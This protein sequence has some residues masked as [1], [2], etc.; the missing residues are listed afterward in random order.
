MKISPSRKS[1]FEILSKF[2]KY[3]NFKIDE[4][5]DNV[6][7]RLNLNSKDRSL[8]MQIVYG[9]LRNKTLLQKILNKFTITN[10]KNSSLEIRVILL[11]SLFQLL[12]LDRVPVYAIVNDG[13]NLAKVMGNKKE[14]SF[15]NAV[16]RRISQIGNMEKIN[17]DIREIDNLSVRFSHPQWIIN[18]LKQRVNENEIKE[19]LQF[20]NSIPPLDIRITAKEISRDD[21]IEEIKK[22]IPK[23]DI[24][25]T[26]FSP[27][28]I[29]ITPPI[30][31]L[32][33][34][35]FR[36]GKCVVQ[37]E[38]A[39]LISYLIKLG[40]GE[41]FL[42]F[43]SAPGG[44]ITHLS[45]LSP[46][47]TKLFATDQSEE[48]L[49]L[50]KKTIAHQNINNISVVSKKEI[51]E[52]VRQIGFFDKILVDAPCS[53]LGTLRRHPEIKWRYSPEDLNSLARKQ[54]SILREIIPLLKKGGT[55]FYSTCSIARSENEDVVQE[56]LKTEKGFSLSKFE[57]D[58]FKIDL[59]NFITEKGYFLT[60]PHRFNLDGFFCARIE[61]NK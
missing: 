10:L 19:A 1:A 4:E 55:I 2:F 38:S 42:D 5:I 24:E 12:F 27:D 3:K 41:M 45:Q 61:Y 48:R 8:S 6:S 37:D 17:R 34:K 40:A 50:V 7:S 29:R 30:F 46:P 25:R 56:F 59:K 18:E 16:L 57:I 31:P 49:E 36:D 14:A 32:E 13:V 43:C 44:K 60:M 28:G 26:P 51:F 58:E 52:I 33:I 20:N 35:A 23:L 21:L 54:I 47:D 53:G 9:V 39:Q 22:E 11:M 15:V